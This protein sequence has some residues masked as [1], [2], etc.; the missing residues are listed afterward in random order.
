MLRKLFKLEFKWVNKFI[1]WFALGAIIF[2]LGSRLTN[3]LTSVA[4]IIIHN[5]L[6][7]IAISI[8]VSLICNAFARSFVHFKSGLFKDEAYLTH[9]LPVEKK[10]IWNSRVLSFLLTVFICLILF[11]T[12]LAILFADKDILDIIKNI[13]NE[14]PIASVSFI[15]TFIFEVVSLGLSVFSGILLG[16]RSDSKRNLRS[17]VI[18]LAIYYSTQL[19]FLGI[20]FILS[21]FLPSLKTVFTESSSLSFTEVA[22]NFKNFFILSG[23]YYV[24]ISILLYYIGMHT[25]SKGVDVE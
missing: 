5:T 14:Y 4:G 19:F 7:S 25:L 6:Q 12:T 23:I 11:L 16:H 24:M 18:S 15:L 21:R 20:V 17:V 3:D 2:A 13:L 1:P 9:T 8:V 22:L 10:D